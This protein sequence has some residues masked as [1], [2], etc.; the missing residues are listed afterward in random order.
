MS[1]NTWLF[2]TSWEVCNKVG[3][4]NTVLRTKIK[5][6]L[7]S[8]GDRYIMVGPWLPENQNFVETIPDHLAPI[9]KILEDHHL[10]FRMGY[11]DAEE[12]KPQV[13]LL[14]YQNR[15]NIADILYSMWSHFNVD[16]L[17]G[18]YEYIEP[19][20]FSTTVADA[21]KAIASNEH[22][23]NANIIA[24]FHEW[25]CG[26]GILFSEH[27]SH[28]ISTVFTT[29]ATVLGRALASDRRDIYNLPATFDPETEA[30]KYGVFAKHSVERAAA[31]EADC[32][33]TV[34][35]LTA[36]EAYIMLGKYP[37]KIV[38]N[39]LDVEHIQQVLTTY[40]LPAIREKLH[41]VASQTLRHDVPANALFWITSGRYEFH[42][43]G[44]DVLLYSLDKLE[45]ELSAE[46]PPIIVLFCI[47]ANNRTEQDSLLPQGHASYDPNQQS[48]LGIATH[49]L[50]DPNRDPIIQTCRELNFNQ[51]SRKISVIYSDSYLHGHDGV[52]NIDYEKILAAC[53]LSIFPSYYEPWGY[54]PLESI[55]YQTP[56]ITTNL[57]GFGSWV[58]SLQLPNQEAVQ[59]LHYGTQEEI[60]TSLSDCLYKTVQ[61]TDAQ[62]QSIREQVAK[63]AQLADWKLFY[64]D[65]LDA[66]D[67][68][69]EFNDIYYEDIQNEYMASYHTVESTTPRFR[70]FQHECQ[71]PAQLS[72]LRD[73]AYNLWWAWHHEVKLLFQGMD[74]VL[75]EKVKRNPIEFLNNVSSTLLSQKM[76]DPGY[77]E[78]YNHLLI[79]FD[80]YLNRKSKLDLEVIHADQP[81]AYFCLEYGLD[82]SLPIYA[83]GLGILAGDYLKS[84]SDVDLPLIAIGLYY[85]QGY[86]TQRVDHQGEQLIEHATIDPKVLPLKQLS[87]DS[88][89]PLLIGVEVQN[90]TIFVGIWKLK[91]G[92]VP[93]Y[94][95]D[96]DVP[97]NNPDDRQITNRL[98]C[99]SKTQRL[100]QEIVLGVAGVRLIADKLAITPSVYHLNE[101]HSA[102]LLL[103][104]IKMLANQGFS[105]SE[106]IEMVRASS[107]FTTHTPVPAGNEVFDETLIKEYFSKSAQLLGVPIEKLLEFA[108]DFDNAHNFSMTILALKLTAKSN[109]VSKIHQRVAQHMW[110]PIWP[111]LLENEVPIEGV[112]NGVHLE[113]WLGIPMR[114]LFD[115][116]LG[117]SWLDAQD[118]PE[119]W[120]KMSLIPDYS[121]WD[122]HQIQ[123]DRLL[124]ILKERIPKEYRRRS[125]KESLIQSSL[126]TLTNQT[127]LIGF[128]RRFATYKRH[129]LIFN[130]RERAVKILTNPQMPVV[131]LIAGK[132]HP[133]DTL[134]KNVLKS[135]IE[136]TR[137]PAFKGH[138]IFLEDYDMSLSKALVQGVDIWLNNP[139]YPKEACGTSG[140]KVAMN[141]GLNFSIRDGWWD[142]TSPQAGWSIDTVEMQTN[143]EKRNAAE[144]DDLL[145]KLEYT[146]APL[147]YDSKKDTRKSEWVARMKASIMEVSCEFNAHHMVKNYL[148]ELYLPLARYSTQLQQNDFADLKALVRWKERTRLHF[149][150]LK[151]KT[152]LVEG[153]K[154][155]KIQTSGELK[156]TLLLFSGKLKAS[157]IKAELI[158]I[159]TADDPM[160]SSPITMPLTLSDK[161]ESGILTYTAEYKIE[162]TGL[163]SYGV[164]I[165]PYHPKLVYPHDMNLM[166]WG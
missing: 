75:W 150:T 79:A 44:F 110:Q 145:N 81:I 56:T 59:V 82:E 115:T 155:G 7:A 137:D 88:G 163:F 116:Y 3:G 134:G 39:G 48:A 57:A 151:I 135:I 4:I 152:L 50:N 19:I 62:K 140:M 126:E 121:L 147:Y 130:N 55:A 16:S 86:L 159:R 30:R 28:N 49:R 18:N 9:A 38:P 93:L 95:L 143:E 111:G 67:Q 29:H 148:S 15:Y 91:V 73:L 117:G 12:G 149:N 20:L 8:F 74:P 47:A 119:T 13:I 156:I 2:E 83:G 24:Q 22:Y 35:A 85:K 153:I 68:A 102:F 108:R 100:L 161:R 78:K 71:L 120:K 34:S 166:I 144:C 125:E 36:D 23:K 31:R 112:T 84:V 109:G 146:I 138:V 37:D 25:L 42:N 41:H 33:T 127:L 45:K 54:T 58:S 26:A 129:D 96:T 107:V 133:A 98:Y 94:L 165:Y 92:K 99:N 160:K 114:I 65:Y 64:Q 132:S 103:E 162:D 52:F 139:I 10:R 6:A 124:N 69:I 142:E 14:D 17:A 97:E 105:H 5:Q 131:L 113:T 76:N 61:Q 87:D 104:R 43:K 128:A 80:Q 77:M 60:V 118:D 70:S 32:F 72:Q 158:L 101:G 157:E 21:I 66:Y 154:N 90:R 40:D 1:E 11:W 122:T 51:P 27:D 63:I 89:K 136:I 53:D 123:K 141:G 164:R 106:A 46:A